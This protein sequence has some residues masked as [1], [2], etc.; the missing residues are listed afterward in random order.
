MAR[1]KFTSMLLKSK[2]GFTLLEVL[3]VLVLISLLFGTLS[4]T[5]YSAL[6]SS[7]DLARDS[8]KLRQEAYLLWNLKRKVV[9]AKILHMEKDKLFMITSAGDYY[10]G[11]VKCAYIYKE[12][13]LYY[14]EFPYPYGDIKFYEEDKLIKLGKFNAFS[15]RAYAGGNFYDTFDGIPE[16]LY[17]KLDTRQLVIKL[18]S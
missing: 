10:D 1:Q 8:Q 3:L 13:V 16:L 6:N 2:K 12:G 14:Y 15:F 7:L 17:V 18:L 11:M 5:Y 4:Y 9:S